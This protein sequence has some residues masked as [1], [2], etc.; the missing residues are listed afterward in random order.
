[1]LTS[2]FLIA[3]RLTIHKLKKIMVGLTEEAREI[4]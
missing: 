1:M 3:L 2:M 4:K